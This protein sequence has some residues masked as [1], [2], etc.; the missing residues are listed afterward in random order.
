MPT[1]KQREVVGRIVANRSTGK[2][3]KE[4]FLEAGYSEHTAIKPSQ[5]ME[6]KGYKDALAECGITENLVGLALK[7]DIDDKGTLPPEKR[8]R[9]P[10]LNLAAKVLRMGESEAGITDGEITISWKASRPIDIDV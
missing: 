3:L 5:V 2:P 4:S 7:K 9:V 10:E 6:S 1:V 8:N